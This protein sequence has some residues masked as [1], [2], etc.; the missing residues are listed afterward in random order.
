MPGKGTS[1][2]LKSLNVEE[3]MHVFHQTLLVRCNY[4]SQSPQREVS[5]ANS[6][7]YNFTTCCNFWSCLQTGTVLEVENK[8]PLYFELPYKSE[9]STQ[10]T[11]VVFNDFIFF[12]EDY[13]DYL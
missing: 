6:V 12:K 5:S 13:L 10:S 8:V 9:Y 11:T 4:P 1:C 7:I 2:L 3:E